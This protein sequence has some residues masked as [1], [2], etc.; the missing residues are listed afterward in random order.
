MLFCGSLPR[1]SL[2]TAFGTFPGYDIDARNEE[3]DK[4]LDFSLSLA[5]STTSYTASDLIGAFATL[6]GDSKRAS[7]AQNAYLIQYSKSTDIPNTPKENGTAIHNGVIG[8]YADLFRK[9]FLHP[10]SIPLEET[11]D[12]KGKPKEKGDFDGVVVASLPWSYKLGKTENKDRIRSAPKAIGWANSFDDPIIYGSN[13]DD[14]MF[15]DRFTKD[16]RRA[17]L[18]GR[19]GNDLLIANQPHS[20]GFDELTGG[21]GD[22]VF[23]IGYQRYGKLSPYE[24]SIKTD[25]DSTGYSIKSYAVVKDF[26]PSDDYLRFGWRKSE[27]AAIQGS[28]LD[29]KI[30]SRYGEGIGFAKDNNLIVY[31]PNLEVSRLRTLQSAKR[32]SFGQYVNLDQDLFI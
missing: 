29:R 23:W 6:A 1:G 22:D 13:A 21:K 18:D 24:E 9:N 20:K 8:V 30:V 32:L 26:N 27:L 25:K 12:A 19:K 28:N 16:S 2:D 3:Q 11:F 17:F 10:V 7:T 15:F 5:E 14:I 4:P 31:I